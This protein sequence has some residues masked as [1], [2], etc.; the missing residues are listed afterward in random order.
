MSLDLF[1]LKFI[2]NLKKF[3]K[4]AIAISCFKLEFRFIFVQQIKTIMRQKS[5]VKNT[6]FC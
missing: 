2:Y 5:K 6:Y 1:E 4:N 3:G